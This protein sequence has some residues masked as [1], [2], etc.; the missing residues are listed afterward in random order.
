MNYG[1]INHFR[2]L[3]GFS[4]YYRS[5]LF[6]TPTY[7]YVYL[8]FVYIL[9]FIYYCLNVGKTQDLRC[10]LHMEQSRA[11]IIKL[12]SAFTNLQAVWAEERWAQVMWSKRM[13]RFHLQRDPICKQGS[14]KA[15]EKHGR[16]ER[17]ENK[18]YL[19]E[20]LSAETKGKK[21]FT[22]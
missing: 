3:V 10:V 16:E 9:I 2:C 18:Y 12:L 14:N 17:L 13:Q 6:W 1:I 21:K 7:L 11:S 4:L 22:H 5:I 20:Q 15:E 19:K 8:C